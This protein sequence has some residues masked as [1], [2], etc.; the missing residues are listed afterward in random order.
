LYFNE[1]PK[2]EDMNNKD[3]FINIK[4]KNDDDRIRIKLTT[5]D[6]YTVA[7]ENLNTWFKFERDDVGLSKANTLFFLRSN[8]LQNT[9]SISLIAKNKNK[10][11]F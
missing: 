5:Y 10:R 7:Y 4:L 9:I 1:L 3:I 11:Y 2:K 8:N 6:L